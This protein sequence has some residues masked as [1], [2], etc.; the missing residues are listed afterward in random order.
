LMNSTL[1]YIEFKKGDF[2]K[3]ID[4]FSKANSENPRNWYYMAQAYNKIGDGINSAKCNNKIMACSV[5]SLELAL[6]RKSTLAELQ[7]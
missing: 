6:Y 3:A 4:Y 1:G 2:K 7:K 5:N